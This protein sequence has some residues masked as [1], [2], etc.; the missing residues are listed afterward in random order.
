VGV[1]PGNG[2]ALA[3]RFSA[4]GYSVALLARRGELA[5]QLATELP[6]AKAYACDAADAGSVDVAFRRVRADLGDVDVLIFNA[7][8]GVWGCAAGFV[9]VRHCCFCAA[10]GAQSFDLDVRFA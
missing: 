5:A 2:E 3:R 9:N 8:S 1:G 7:G 6:R 4:D 10:S